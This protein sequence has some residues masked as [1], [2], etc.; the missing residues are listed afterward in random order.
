MPGRLVALLLVSNQ[1]MFR[2]WIF[3]GCGW[4]PRDPSQ[5]RQGCSTPG[6]SRRMLWSCSRPRVPVHATWANGSVGFFYGSLFPKSYSQQE[7]VPCQFVKQ[8]M[9]RATSRAQPWKVTPNS[10]PPTAMISWCD[11]FRVTLGGDLCPPWAADPLVLQH[12]PQQLSL[13]APGWQDQPPASPSDQPARWF[14]GKEPAL[15]AEQCFGR[16]QGQGQALPQ[17]PLVQAHCQAVEALDKGV[18]GWLALPPQ[19][20]TRTASK[21]WQTTEDTLLGLSEKKRSYPQTIASSCKQK[22]TNKTHNRSP[23]RPAEQSGGGWQWQ[24]PSSSVPRTLTPNTSTRC[25]LAEPLATRHPFCLARMEPILACRPPWLCQSCIYQRLPCQ[26]FSTSPCCNL[27]FPLSAPVRAA[28]PPPSPPPP[29]PRELDVT[30]GLTRV[31]QKWV[32]NFLALK[33][34]PGFQKCYFQIS[35]ASEE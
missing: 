22:M 17:L 30:Q 4:L 19:V 28:S 33:S 29:P 27:N 5:F 8:E 31:N 26:E 2:R 11:M 32:S 1:E 21:A 12:L 9:G 20:P 13:S 14:Q 18:H 35:P 3:F 6:P 23:S 7:C 10:S 24:G 25:C 16:R 15:V 34:L